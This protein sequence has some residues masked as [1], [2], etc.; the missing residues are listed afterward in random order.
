M[1]SEI[2]G[3]MMLVMIMLFGCMWYECEE[4]GFTVRGVLS[5]SVSRY[6]YCMTTLAWS[7]D[8]DE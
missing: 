4:G 5:P 1:G 6:Y 2:G 8:V 3:V 7:C